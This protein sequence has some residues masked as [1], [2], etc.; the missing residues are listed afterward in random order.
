MADKSSQSGSMKDHAK[1][2]ASHA[3]QAASHAGQ[4][5]SEGVG[6]ARQ[7]ASEAAGQARQGASTLGQ[8]AQD[9]AGAASHKADQALSSVGEG[10]S[11]LAGTLRE[12][13]PQEGMLGSAA[14][15]VAQG[16]ESSGHYLQ[17]H[18]LSDIGADINGLVRRYPLAAVGIALG[19]G[20]MLGSALRR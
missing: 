5:V 13:A 18:G 1:Q 20:F 19:L 4:A 17:E 12:K 16:L 6:Q 7:A 8:K 10:M 11:S 15:A 3:G 9:M 2:A 14:S